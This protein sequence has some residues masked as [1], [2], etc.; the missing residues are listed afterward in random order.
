MW[1]GLLA[2]ALLGGCVAQPAAAPSGSGSVAAAESATGA[3]TGAPTDGPVVGSPA[4]ARPTGSRSAGSAVTTAPT[5]ASGPPELGVFGD[6]I[7]VFSFHNTPGGPE[8]QRE[9]EGWPDRLAAA[10]APGLLVRNLAAGGSWLSR[11]NP[12]GQ[13]PPIAAT[14]VPGMSRLANPRY[15]LI[16]AGRNDLTHVPVSVL[17]QTAVGIV[18]AAAAQGWQVGFV[19]ILPVNDRTPYRAATDPDR[20][21][22]NRWLESTYAVR[23]LAADAVLDL[24]HDGQL[25]RAFDAGDG[26]HLNTAGST[27]LAAAAAVM[28]RRAGWA[29]C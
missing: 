6:S 19:T 4:P 16:L 20:L 1:L 21:A 13:V 28:V 22:Y 24:D 25:D 12:V 3:A 18:A 11:V 2:A 7:S 8:P 17:E 29:A 27:A 5:A 26:F 10:V 15:V 23:V 14:V 9:S